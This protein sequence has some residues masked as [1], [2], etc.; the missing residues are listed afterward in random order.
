MRSEHK[1]EQ[2]LI[3]AVLA[4]ITVSIK[5]LLHIPLLL[6][7]EGESLNLPFLEKLC[8]NTNLPS[9]IRGFQMTVE[10]IWTGGG[11]TA[12]HNQ[13]PAR[14]N[15]RMWRPHNVHSLH[16]LCGARETG[17]RCACS[18]YFKGARTPHQKPPRFK[19]TSDFT[20]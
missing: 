16:I 10:V 8:A 19:L 7:L 9:L 3:I 15:E 11:P 12:K 5:H 14:G 17:N 6:F 20:H 1:T 13:H 2:R 18:Q 4:A